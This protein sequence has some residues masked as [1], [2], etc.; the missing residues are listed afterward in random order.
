MPA[1]RTCPRCGTALASDALEG[2]CPKCVGRAVFADDPAIPS[3]GK[4]AGDL[5]GSSLTPE[6]EAELA[7]LKP[8]E[9]GEVIG[10]Y[11]LLEQIGE[12]GFGTVWVADQ[13]RP[14]RR[15]IALKIIKLGMDTKEVIARF[16]QERQALAMMDH[17]HIA[18]VF[19]AGATQWG[20]PFFVMELVRGIKITEYCDQA[21]LPTAE[22]LALFIQVCNAVQHAHQKGII[23]RDLKP[24]NILVT[25]HDG[26][27][28][29]KVIDFGVAKATQKQRLTDLTIYTQ[30]QQMIGTPL[31]MSP[32]QAEMS[33]LDID[34]RSDIYSLGVLLYELLTGRTPFDPEELMRKGHDDIRRAIRE[35]E[36]KKP[37]TFLRTM[38][39]ELRTSVAQHRHADCAK[40]IGQIRGDLDWIVMKAIE[41]DRTRRYES[42]NEFALDIQR[43]LAHEPV[44]AR[45]A[46]TLYRF[47]RLV[48]RNRI[49]FAAGAAVAV[50]L[51]AGVIGIALQWRRAQ[52]AELATRERLA[53][54]HVRTGLRMTEDADALHGLPHFVEALRLGLG[55]ADRERVARLRFEMMIRQSP[56]LAQ[57]WL[58]KEKGQAY[59]AEEAGRVLLTDG[60]DAHIFDAD[61]GA[62]VFAPLRH[63]SE[64]RFVWTDREV[65]RV[66][67]EMRSGQVTV[68]EPGAARVL[69]K[70]SGVAHSRAV[71]GGPRLRLAVRSEKGR[72]VQC[73]SARDGAVDATFE[74]PDVVEWAVATPDGTRVLAATMDSLYL[75]DVASQMLVVPPVVFGGRPDFGMFDPSGHLA[76]L[77]D[78]SEDGL[79]LFD[80]TTGTFAAR[81]GARSMGATGHGWLDGKRWVVL[82]RNFSGSTLRDPVADRLLFDAPNGTG[83]TASSFATRRNVF[84]MA[85][86]NGTAQLWD[87]D[88]ARAI[89]PRLWAS[90]RAH[91]IQLG[92]DA[93]KLLVITSEPAVRLWKMPPHGGA[94]WTAVEP[95]A[96]VAT[97][98]NAKSGQLCTVGADGRLTCRDATTG[99]Q[100]AE[101]MQLDEAPLAVVPSRAGRFFFAA[102]AHGA[103]LW[104]AETRRAAGPRIPCAGAIRSVTLDAAGRLAAILAGEKVLLC[105]PATGTVRHTLAQPGVLRCLLSP[106]GKRL[107]AL[108][109]TTAQLWDTRNGRAIGEPIDVDLKRQLPYATFDATGK[110]LAVWWTQPEL[111]GHVRVIDPVTGHDLQPPYEHPAVVTSAAFSPSGDLLVTATGAQQL[112]LWRTA[113]GRPALTPILHANAISAVGFSPDELLFWSRSARQLYAWEA[114]TGDAAAPALHHLGPPPPEPGRRPGGARVTSDDEEVRIAWSADQRVATCDGRGGV[115]LWDFSV[116]TRPLGEMDVI[117][118]VLSSH[119]TDPSGGLVPLTREE[120][121]A[122]WE[123]WRKIAPPGE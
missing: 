14:V 116:A 1:E 79:A 74:H 32:E 45:P 46:S 73:I 12:G 34:T 64:L 5:P 98:W 6:I 50:A 18:K 52:A 72:S 22:R 76:G 61:T 100:A 10:P 103:R 51:L 2:L 93:T 86:E 3:A 97:W 38:A 9:A 88:A 7:R 114:A 118:R 25:L 60:Q 19:D 91:A 107:A 47:R 44:L 56:R 23:H 35:Q 117:A 99:H 55:S 16:E 37:S 80:V 84:A 27:P 58:G 75:W 49:V 15:R 92:A 123:Q 8:E 24:S 112:W 59:L 94:V 120:L 113:D 31:Y 36:P 77:R 71:L 17:P 26:V 102:D 68:W 121:R 90:G 63:A 82:A 83:T 13:E 104:D 11:K 57:L 119:R 110:R 115:N 62:E 89:P 30:F 78:R 109:F 85:G 21:N 53:H 54:E 105:D 122:A 48:R 67:T 81:G 108:T 106:D 111:P 39:L 41:K 29:P 20:R 40:L 66:V 70:F 96:A 33:G 69:A 43:H 95:A 42:A 101:P 65:S 28:V 4:E 87:A